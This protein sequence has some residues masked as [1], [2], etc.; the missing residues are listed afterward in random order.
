MYPMA[1]PKR[2]S[3]EDKDFETN[4]ENCMKIYYETRCLQQLCLFEP[5]PRVCTTY[6]C[7]DQLRL[8]ASLVMLQ[9]LSRTSV[10]FNFRLTNPTFGQLLK[11]PTTRLPDRQLITK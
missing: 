7:L 9:T 10:A 2:Q 11:L 5:V 3:P 6:A 8:F 1:L 4:R